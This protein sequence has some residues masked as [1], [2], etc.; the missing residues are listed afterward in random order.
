MIGLSRRQQELLDYIKGHVTTTGR[1]PTVTAASNLLGISKANISQLVR[2]LE[3]KGRLTRE[4]H[5]VFKL[6]DAD[7]PK[8]TETR[9][10]LRAVKPLTKPIQ[11]PT[12]AAPAFAAELYALRSV[13][14]LVVK[15]ISELEQACVVPVRAETRQM[16]AE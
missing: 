16:D 9:P 6:V 12:A 10:N 8:P 14:E 11:R 1:Y 13:A 7:K 4:A 5:G 3:N 2:A 15:R